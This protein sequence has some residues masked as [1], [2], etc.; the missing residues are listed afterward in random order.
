[1][2]LTKNPEKSKIKSEIL[3]KKYLQPL[4]IMFIQ[5]LSLL[6]FIDFLSYLQKILQLIV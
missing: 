3:E 4:T 6:L 5:S 1:M 2:L